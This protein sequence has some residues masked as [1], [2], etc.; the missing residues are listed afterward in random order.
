MRLYAISKATGSAT[1]R[2]ESSDVD[3]LALAVLG[4]A[5]ASQAWNN[6]M[7]HRKG[8]RWL[9]EKGSDRITVLDTAFAVLNFGVVMAKLLRG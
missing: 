9:V 6:L 7:V 1:A 4:I 3:V 5:N 2:E 8:H